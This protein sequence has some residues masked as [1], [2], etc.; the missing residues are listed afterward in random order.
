MSFRGSNVIITNPL[1]VKNNGTLRMGATR[2]VLAAGNM[3]L[4]PNGDISVVVIIPKV[5]FLGW[6]GF[7]II[8]A[9]CI[10]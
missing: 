5:T 10:G 1:L 7:G 9:P 8:V 6:L 3:Q 2:R 4:T